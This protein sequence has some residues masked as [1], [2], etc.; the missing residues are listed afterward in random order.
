[1]RYLLLALL[2][3]AS[4]VSAQQPLTKPGQDLVPNERTAI[5]IAEA[6]LA[7]IYGSETIERQRP[8]NATLENGQWHV[9]GTLPTWARGGVAEAWIVKEDGRVTKVAHGR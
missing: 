1:M 3:F 5:A 2:F 9:Q 8:F 4:F 7:P 6:V